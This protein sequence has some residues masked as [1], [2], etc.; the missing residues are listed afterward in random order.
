MSYANKYL[1]MFL[2][3]RPIVEAMFMEADAEITQAKKHANDL[4]D[5]LAKTEKELE[6]L[7]NEQ[8]KK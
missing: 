2:N 7:K 6:E 1:K 8:S 4:G 3:P 5:L